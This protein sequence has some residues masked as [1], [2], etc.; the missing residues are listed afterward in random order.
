MSKKILFNS[1]FYWQYSPV[2]FSLSVSL[3]KRGHEILMVGCGELPQYCELERFDIPK[4][5]CSNCKKRLKSYFDIYQAPYCFLSDFISKEEIKIANKLSADLDINTM[6]NYSLHGVPVGELSY[7][8]MFQYFRG[9]PFDI[10]KEKEPTYRRIF[11]SSVLFVLSKKKILEQYKPDIVITTNGKFLQ[12]SPLV[13][14]AKENNIDFITWEDRKLDKDLAYSG[15][16]IQRD[17]FAVE[18]RIDDVWNEEK[19]KTLSE[20]NQK[21]LDEYFKKWSKGEHSLI[22]Y[23]DKRKIEDREQI[24]SELNLKRDRPLISLFPNVAWDGSVVKID[25]AFKG[26]FDWVFFILEVAEKFEDY[27]FVIRAHPSE[28]KAPLEMRTTTPIDKEV[29]KRFGKIPD[30]VK[31]ITGESSISSYEIAKM[32]DIV[33]LYASTLGLELALKGVKP[34]IVSNVYYSRKGFTKDIS[35]KEELMLLLAKQPFD[36]KLTNEE[37]QLARKFAHIT[38]FRR[39]FSFPS[40]DGKKGTFDPPNEEF[41][42]IGKNKTLDDLCDYI[43]TGKPF[44]DIGKSMNTSKNEITKIE[45]TDFPS[46]KSQA[47]QNRFGN[48]LIT[49]DNKLKF[50]CHDLL[51]FYMAFKDI[52]ANRIYHL[53][54]DNKKP[55]VI[56]GGGH[57]GLFS[58]YVK[59]NFPQAK[60]IT[61][62]PEK[63][64]LDFLRKNL[65]SN[66]ISD[67]EIVEAGLYNKDGEISFGSDD[68][69]GSSIFAEANQKINVVK[70]SPYLNEEIDFL[71]LNIEGAEL[72]VLL[73]IENKLHN[74]KE[75]VIE[76]H[77]FQEI[78]Q[79]LH[80]ILNILDRNGFRYMIHDFDEE[81]NSASKPPFKIDERTKFFNLIYA[82]RIYSIEDNSFNVNSNK[83]EI[84][85][86]KNSRFDKNGRLY[87]KN[88][89][90]YRGMTNY[91]SSYYENL[92]NVIE[93]NEILKNGIIPSK[94]SKESLENYKCLLEHKVINPIHYPADWSISMFRDALFL[95]FD[96]HLELLKNGYTLQDAHLW[97]IVFDGTQPQ[98]IDFG[99]IISDKNNFTALLNEYLNYCI[100]PLVLMLLGGFE[101]ARRYLRNG[102]NPH[103]ID[104]DL[105]GYFLVNENSPITK[106]YYA[107]IELLKQNVSDSNSFITLLQ[108]VREIIK[109]ISYVDQ[110]STWT[111]YH[112]AEEKDKK[113]G[114]RTF[115]DEFFG[116]NKNKTVLDVGCASGFY[117]FLAA[118]EGL[119]TVAVDIDQPAIDYTYN[120]YKDKNLSLAPICTNIFDNKSVLNDKKYDIVLAL[121]IIHHLCFTQKMSLPEILEVLQKYCNEYL[122]IEYI[123]DNDTFVKEHIDDYRFEYSL[124]K[125]K[126]AVNKYYEIEDIV[127]STSDNRKLLLCRKKEMIKKNLSNKLEPISRLFGFD[128]GKPIDRFYIEKFLSE[129]SS[130]INGTVLEIGDNTYTLNYGKKVTKSEILNYQPS[131]NCTIVGDLST[132][133]NIPNANFDCI[134]LTQTLQFIYDINSA[135]QNAYNALKPGGTIL[136]TASGISQISRYDMDRWGEFWRF[137]DASLKKVIEE[138]TKNALVNVNYYGN[139]ELAKAFLDGKACEDVPANL[140]EYNDKDYQV[141]LTAKITKPSKIG[142]IKNKSEKE[143][144]PTV[145]LYHRVANDPIDSQL[146]S[147]SPE[148]FDSQI[149]FLTENYNVIPLKEMVNNLLNKTLIKNTLS[150]TFDDGYADNLFNALPILE[151]Y[152]AH[153]TIFISTGMI[154]KNRE[155]WWDDMERVFFTKK[156]LPQV[157]SISDETQNINFELSDYESRVDIYDKLHIL[158]KNNKHSERQ[159]FIDELLKW[160]DLPLKGRETNRVMTK[161]ELNII[162]KSKYIELGAH[163]VWH[164]SLSILNSEEQAKEIQNSIENL[165]QIINEK[166]DLFSYPFGNL[167]DLNEDT[168][169]I[170]QQLGFKNAIAN[171]QGEINI[172]TN[173]FLIPRRLVRNWSMDE[174][175]KWLNSENKRE[176]EKYT[177]SK[178]KNNI[179]NYLSQL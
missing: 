129:N 87:Y 47:K 125:L 161:N 17:G 45:F 167:N 88:D 116:K 115:F 13:Y 95:H 165:S 133:K 75:I 66:G 43:L 77:G 126:E 138:N 44:L 137:T 151:K 48:W 32:S 134:I 114:K 68:S 103:L 119:K 83:N 54:T 24:L 63:K 101:K 15:V 109:Q 38:R 178:R 98:Y 130:L 99:S 141:L 147:V 110:K 22:A 89:I 170:L 172:Q 39:V 111:V 52:F 10:D 106:G 162:N 94:L 40:L 11:H 57:I 179:I 97:N 135:L 112:E 55:K 140:F 154:E 173:P 122:I 158:L 175:G 72:D 82:K 36:N 49:F 58:V 93:R 2:E 7:I 14:M 156:I 67:V 61:F 30:N 16:M 127:A 146:L 107:I 92:I 29:E 4:P 56:D 177:V 21:Q 163:T 169:K 131:E 96:I 6:R 113:H 59:V 76:Y 60:V 5:D 136:L 64:S 9:Y 25:T 104:E 142:N 176:L 28:Y 78:G 50:Y 108:K 27:D 73:E 51:S 124:D 34:W 1:Q 85:W 145:L 35:S 84:E 65:E 148:H 149:K 80:Q 19:G 168:I 171:I 69:D 123:S 166:V 12:W 174:F 86:L 102:S 81:T 164:D 155:F 132:G 31:I 157:L 62:E 33:M 159:K 3:R 8:N 79:K 23:Y 153:A 143:I 37:I 91:E 90:L 74:V 150:I 160:A 46:L 53:V 128:R 117:S 20:E 41:F 120:R 105:Y 152:N 121:A 18:G 118:K 144:E 70:L 100:R 26:I 42:E 139:V 71:K